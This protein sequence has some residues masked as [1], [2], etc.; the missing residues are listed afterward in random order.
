MENFVTY[1][2]KVIGVRK[3]KQLTS[4]LVARSNWFKFG[5]LPDGEFEITVKIENQSWLMLQA[6]PNI[7]P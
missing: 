1:T 6:F 3:V 7:R 5:P 2:T 4:K